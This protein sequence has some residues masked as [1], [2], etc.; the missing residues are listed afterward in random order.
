M[1]ELLSYSKLMEKCYKDPQFLEDNKEYVVKRKLEEI[2]RKRQLEE[3]ERLK[4]KETNKENIKQTRKKYYNLNKEKIVEKNKEYREKNKEKIAEQ[5]REY[6][7][8][9]REKLNKQRRE[10][11]HCD[12]CNCYITKYDVKRH[13]QTKKHIKNLG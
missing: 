9:N 2:A 7:E 4:R 13:E 1:A 3:I 11:V 5:Q 6:R 12:V 10:K 8:T